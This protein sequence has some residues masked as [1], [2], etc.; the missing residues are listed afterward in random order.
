M[1]LLINFPFV[2]LINNFLINK[3]REFDIYQYLTLNSFN[4]SLLLN[5]MKY[6]QSSIIMW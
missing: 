4:T 5:T 1:K 3:L 2:Y 6:K